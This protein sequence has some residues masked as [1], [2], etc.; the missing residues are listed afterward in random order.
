MSYEVESAAKSL[1]FIG[2]SFLFLGL[3]SG[4]G[5][6]SIV[7]AAGNS[8]EIL[9]SSLIGSISMR[10][11]LGESSLSKLMGEGL[12]FF[13]FFFLRLFFYPEIKDSIP[14]LLI[15]YGWNESY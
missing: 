11:V 1:A 14:F 7:D 6:S 3:R 4:S 5:F 15:F 10:E 9:L 12:L 2:G 8:W 13:L